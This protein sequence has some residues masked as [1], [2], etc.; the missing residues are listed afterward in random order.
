MTYRRVEPVDVLL[1]D[2]GALIL[3]EHR[4][5]RLS[6][7]GG[8]VFERCTSPAT[9]EQLA[10]HLA[11]TFGTPPDASP[12]DATRTIVDQMVALGVLVDLPDPDDPAAPGPD[13][14]VR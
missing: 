6:P 3:L 10:G 2:E 7:L 8:E 12:L 5:I 14:P 4:L 9:L 1:G 13:A 11:A